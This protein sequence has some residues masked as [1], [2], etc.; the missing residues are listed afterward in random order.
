MT[1]AAKQRLD[2]LEIAEGYGL[3][4]DAEV[5]GGCSISVA[6]QLALDRPRKTDTILQSGKYMFMMDRFTQRYVQGEL[7]LDFEEAKGFILQN[8]DS[9]LS[10]GLTVL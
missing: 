8:G 7:T 3:R 5:K 9:I 4:I 6:I 1:E 2:Q 10:Q